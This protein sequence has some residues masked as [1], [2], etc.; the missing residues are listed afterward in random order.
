[1]SRTRKQPGDALQWSARTYNDLMQLLDNQKGK[2]AKG[3]L[4]RKLVKIPA[5]TWTAGTAKICVV[6]KIYG[7]VSDGNPF[8]MINVQEE[9]ILVCHPGP[10]TIE[11]GENPPDPEYPYYDTPDGSAMTGVAEIVDGGYWILTTVYC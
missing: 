11:N 2:D 1:M 9:K 6:R 4:G 3:G 8:G 10:T 7:S 5:G